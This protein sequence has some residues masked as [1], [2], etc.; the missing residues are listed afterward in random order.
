MQEPDF[1]GSPFRDFRDDVTTTLTVAAVL[2]V[3]QTH[4]RFAR[5]K[6]GR[7]TLT[8][9][10]KPTDEALLKPLVQKLLSLFPGK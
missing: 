6:D 10:K 5:G 8:V 9:E 3:L 4:I 7:W 2:L 1:A